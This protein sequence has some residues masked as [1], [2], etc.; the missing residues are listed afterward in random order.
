MQGKQILDSVLI[1]NECLD[2]C[3]REGVLSVLCELDMENVYDHG[4]WD[5]LFYMLARCG[6]RKRWCAWIRHCV[7]IT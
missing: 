1:L 5:F 2:S 7:S 4:Y 6:F 3:L